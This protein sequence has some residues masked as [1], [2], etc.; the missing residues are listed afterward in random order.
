MASAKKVNVIACATDNNK[1]NVES[2]DNLTVFT[3]Y[4]KPRNSSVRIRKLIKSYQ[5]ATEDAPN[6]LNSLNPKTIVF[7]VWCL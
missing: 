4:Q 7:L 5:K 2:N 6:P 3:K 1:N